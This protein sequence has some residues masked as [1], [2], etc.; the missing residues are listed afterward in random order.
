[1]AGAFKRLLIWC[2]MMIRTETVTCHLP[3]HTCADVQCACHGI[4]FIDEDVSSSLL[5]EKRG[6]VAETPPSGREGRILKYMQLDA[7]VIRL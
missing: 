2:F 4:L 7:C 5:P 3:E 1:M 6:C